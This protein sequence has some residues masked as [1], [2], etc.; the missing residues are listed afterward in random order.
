MY[1]YYAPTPLQG[2]VKDVASQRTRTKNLPVVF[3]AFVTVIALTISI[4]AAF[5][6][7]NKGPV[8]DA[9]SVC[10]LSEDHAGVTKVDGGYEFQTGKPHLVDGGQ[11]FCVAETAGM[12]YSDIDRLNDATAAQGV[13]TAVWER[14]EASWEVSDDVLHLV[15]FDR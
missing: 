10:G 11:L 6:F 15:L 8:A 7:S 12:P 13:V 2:Y 5:M 1:G 4:T 9:M 14:V 3:Y